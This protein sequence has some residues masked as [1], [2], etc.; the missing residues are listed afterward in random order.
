MTQKP[1]FSIIIPCYNVE[2]Y[3]DEAIRSCLQQQNM[4]ETDFEIIAINDGSQD[5]TLHIL[6][7]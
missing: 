6:K 2:R 5:A 7:Q 4:S 1:T 3:I